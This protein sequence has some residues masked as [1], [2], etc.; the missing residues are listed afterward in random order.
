MQ[1]SL[2]K[3]NLVYVKKE[4]WNRFRE[5]LESNIVD[6]WPSGY[7]RSENRFQ[8]LQHQAAFQNRDIF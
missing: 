3:F 2:K 7:S 8:L 5:N 6:E 1:Y 4:F